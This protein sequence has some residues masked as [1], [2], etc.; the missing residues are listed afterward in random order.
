MKK[1]LV[2]VAILAGLSN[3]FGGMLTDSSK[4]GA[5]TTSKVD[6]VLNGVADFLDGIVSTPFNIV[7]ILAGKESIGI[8]KSLFEL[9]GLT[10][11]FDF[12][13]TSTWDRFLEGLMGTAYY[14][15]LLL[16]VVM[17]AN[18]AIN[19]IKGLAKRKN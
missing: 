5:Y 16:F 14:F 7:L 11:G 9:I 4:I 12:S 1:F 6:L 8:V 15:G 3:A 13:P 19:A 2:L 18:I 10:S 17:V